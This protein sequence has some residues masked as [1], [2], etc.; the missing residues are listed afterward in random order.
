MSRRKRSNRVKQ[1]KSLKE[2][3][4]TIK[5]QRDGGS[6]AIRG[7]NFQFLYAS[8]QILKELS[9]GDN[10]SISLEGIE[11]IDILHCNEFIQVKSS[12]NPIDASIFW[13]MNVLKN[14][15]E[16]YKS[17][18]NLNFRFVHNTIISNGNIKG[19]EKKKFD[20]KALKYWIDKVKTLDG[21]KDINIQTFLH[22]ITFE[23]VDIEDLIVK[24]KKL[25]LEKFNLNNDTEE[26]FLI[27]LLYHVSQ[28]SEQRKTINYI[29]LL[30]VIQ[31]VKDASSKT[32]TN[33]AIEQ[34]LITNISYA[35]DDNLT[36]QGYFD[37][38]SA[39]PIHIAL[40]L[41]VERKLW[42]IKI[43]E[44]IKEFDVTVIKSSSGQGKSTLAWKVAEE[45]QKEGFSIYQLN[46]CINYEA[47][48]EI[49]DFIKTRVTI[50]H[51]PLIVV[52]GLD[53]RVKEWDKLAER[54]FDLPVKIIVTTR[55]EDWYR[56]G[57]DTS[58]VNLNV[59][60]I[61]LFQDEAKSIF[62]Q[63]KE[64]NKLHKNIINWQSIWERIE[65]KGLLIEY[66][67]L[68]THGSMIKERLNQQIKELNQEEDDVAAKLEILRMVSLADILNI[69][70]Q[71]KKLTEYIQQSIGFSSDR[72][73]L[74]KIL[75]NE[76]YVQFDKKYVEGL[77]PVRSQHLVDILHET[78][79]IEESLINLLKLIDNESIYDYFI[80]VPFLI[81]EED[82]KDFFEATS[83]IIAS[84]NFI[85]IVEALDG[86]MHYEPYSYWLENKDIYDD[87]YNQGLI[88]LFVNFNPPFSDLNSLE[89]INK[90]L[91]TDTSKY[92]VEQK[93]NLS[94]FTFE[95]TFVVMF[96]LCLSKK[97]V[98]FKLDKYSSY[99]GLA[100]L[101]KWF[102]KTKAVIPEF[103][104]FDENFLLKELQSKEVENV[105][106]LYVYFHI[107]YPQEYLQFIERYKYTLFSILKEKTNSLIIQESDN[108]LDI[109][110]LASNESMDKL[111][112]CSME[113]IDILKEIF[114]HYNKF[115]SKVIYLPFPNEEMYK[116]AVQESYKA[117][118]R[119]N[120]FDE[121][122]IHLNVIWRKTIMR[123]YSY[124]TIYEWQEYY[125]KLRLKFIEFMKACNKLFEYILEGKKTK[126][127]YQLYQ[128][129]FSLLQIEK[130]FPVKTI[131]YNDEEE[132]EDELKNINDFKSSYKNFVNQLTSI[133]DQSNSHLP[134]SNLHDA[135]LR[136]SAMQNAFDTIQKSTY[137]YFDMEIIKKEEILWLDRLLKTVQFFV[138][139]PRK[140]IVGAKEKIL[141]WHEG[142]RK[143]ELETVYAILESLK[144]EFNY[145][146]YYPVRV[147]EK[148]FKEIVIGIED[149][150]EG[151]L[152]EILFSLVDFYESNIDYINIIRVHN[153]EA[154]YG[155][156]VSKACLEKVQIVLDGGEYVESEFGNP[157]LVNIT[158]ELL[159]TLNEKI[160]MESQPEDIP[161]TIFIEIMYDIWKLTEYRNHLDRDNEIENEWLK[162]NELEIT[163]RIREKI[164]I[165]SADEKSFIIQVMDNKKSILKD[166]IVN[167]MNKKIEITYKEMS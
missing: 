27:A 46:Y 160:V 122:D 164:N 17:D 163:N 41:P 12:K 106:D 33:K 92:V 75:E 4:Q 131:K 165:L 126:D 135:Y 5:E 37:G 19:F 124:E 10:H 23:K 48:E 30:D 88:Q 70:I 52:D 98:D 40:G 145:K 130:E 83:E 73:E 100:Y 137:E 6:I 66:V 50:G 91:Q 72:G 26:Q 140:T 113:R 81:G 104:I 162:N 127:I 139:V 1:N 85:N 90:T 110:Y 20:D 16:V 87:V 117:I 151:D 119:E 94:I 3:L 62:M 82:K 102:K 11:D 77:H 65:A 79:S 118:P 56:Y 69:K 2:N 146:V 161:K 60:D 57:L 68:L 112:E 149:F 63:L 134:L 153:K 121:F 21:W 8:Y 142:K 49:V 120:L 155:F 136:L 13:N 34:N 35:I 114:V 93:N 9:E 103:M 53:Q 55:E 7:F 78:L 76:Y 96:C 61:K 125:R 42:Q 22:K 154:S 47:V 123:Q 105:V 54:V 147:I 18:K 58:K 99:D 148:K 108:E 59:V 32:P 152:G 141:V 159:S 150:E 80:T 67:Y 144:I 31:F 51:I 167:Y 74:Y 158:D 115:N 132:F 14:Y 44:S 39:K 89:E 86:L 64:K 143:E 156:R 157:I 109:Q 45:F 95:N 133:L 128:E 71:T 15:L 43:K 28:W 97:M 101:I 107:V 116:Y 84:K 36:D 138:D 25:L 166:E 29:D 111:N 38:K 129:I 24:C